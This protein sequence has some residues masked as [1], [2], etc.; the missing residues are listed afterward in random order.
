MGLMP[1]TKACRENPS[2]KQTDVPVSMT[3]NISTAVGRCT[4]DCEQ[5]RLMQTHQSSLGERVAMGYTVYRI[6]TRMPWT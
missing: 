6:V 5:Q 3:S 2:C 4:E 1:P